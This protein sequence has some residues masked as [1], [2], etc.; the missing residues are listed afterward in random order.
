[1]NSGQ[2]CLSTNHVYVDPSVHDEFVER[3]GYH[4]KEFLKNGRKDDMSHIISDRNFERVAGLLEGTQGNVVH[5][6]KQDKATRYIQPTVITDVT[7]QGELRINTIKPRHPGC[8]CTV[9]RVR[10][11][12]GM[13]AV[14]P[15]IFKASTLVVRRTAGSRI[16]CL[17]CQRIG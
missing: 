17:I 2:I 10:V 16:S 4:L 14:G 15:N 7:L 9:W 6:G 5:G 1:M 12:I 11:P 13:I 8:F 3:V